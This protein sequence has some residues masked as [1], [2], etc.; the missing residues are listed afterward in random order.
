MKK[1]FRI[2]IVFFLMFTPFLVRGQSGSG[3]EVTVKTSPDIPAALSLWTVSLLIDHPVP[4]EVTIMA[5]PFTGTFFLDQVLK[6]PTEPAKT[7]AEYRFMLNSPGPSVLDSFTVIT[8]WGSTLTSPIAIEVQNSLGAREP[9]RFRLVWEGPAAVPVG[10]SVVFRLGT[11]GKDMRPFPAAEIPSSQIPRG[12]ILEQKQPGGEE[13]NAGLVLLLKIIPLQEAAFSIPGGTAASE[14][15]LFEIPSLNFTAYF[16]AAGD[17]SGNTE[18]IADNAGYSG[19]TIPPFPV[20]ESAENK[21]PLLSKAFHRDI[22]SVYRTASNL[23]ERGYLAESLGELRRNERDHPAG[24][25]FL[26]LRRKAEQSLG[27]FHTAGE[28]HQNRRKR[29]LALAAAFLAAIPAAF[30]FRK[31]SGFKY[32]VFTAAAVFLCL[33]FAALF[34][35]PSSS[36][37]KVRFGVGRETIIR[38]VPDIAGEASARFRE[39]QPLRIRNSG[40]QEGGKTGLWVWAEANAEEG[41]SGWIQAEAVV[42]Y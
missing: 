25:L 2:T 36:G 37:G 20:L 18:I 14:N 1:L 19:K 5:P 4:D 31:K 12:L 38:R 13:K 30:F 6:I 22:E 9:R 28:N 27:I 39:G 7:L 3:P 34:G 35:A 16:P 41:E 42:F 21:H 40:G 26:D 24:S 29:L 32:I 33:I 17:K 23:W 15:A 10:E 8:P 11:G